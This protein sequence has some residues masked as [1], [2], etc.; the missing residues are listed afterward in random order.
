MGNFVG[1]LVEIS[2]GVKPTHAQVG[3]ADAVD[4]SSNPAPSLQQPM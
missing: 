3:I 1:V 2:I 4:A